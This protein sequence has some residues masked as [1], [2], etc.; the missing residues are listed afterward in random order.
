LANPGHPTVG[1]GY[2]FY[3]ILR[4]ISYLTGQDRT[5]NRKY[6]KIVLPM[7]FSFVVFIIII[8]LLR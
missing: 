2:V 4:I 8:I 1:V 5:R 3:V 6:G 7:V